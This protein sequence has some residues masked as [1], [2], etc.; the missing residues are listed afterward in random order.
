[1][2]VSFSLVMVVLGTV[3]VVF[4]SPVA[5]RSPFARRMG[6]GGAIGGV[7]QCPLDCWNEAAG[8]VDC[9]P[10]SDDVCLCG[11]F[12]DEVSN[13]AAATCNIG[14]NLSA[15]DFMEAVCN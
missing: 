2:K 6:P 1:M 11:K 8:E 13:C 10:E 7:G 14:E 15:L 12:F 4:A 9:D 5:A 3:S